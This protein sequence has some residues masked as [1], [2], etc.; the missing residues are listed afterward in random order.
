MKWKPFF[1]F[2]YFIGDRDRYSMP[3]ELCILHAEF[4]YY[5]Y[6]GDIPFPRKLCSVYIDFTFSIVSNHAMNCHLYE[7]VYEEAT[8][9]GKTCSKVEGI[10]DDRIQWKY[11][12][13]ALCFRGSNMN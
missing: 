2:S 6:P 10:A 5:Y 8:G 7:D 11:F 13:D 1:T 12:T 4:T 3:E 9:V